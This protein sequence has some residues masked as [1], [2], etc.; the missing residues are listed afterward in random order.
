[1]GFLADPVKSTSDTVSHIGSVIAND[2]LANA[3]VSAVGAYF[4]V[5]TWMTAAGM[6]ANSLAQGKD[7]GQSLLSAGLSYGAG[8]GTNSLLA[9]PELAPSAPG[10][11]Q[12]GGGFTPIGAGVDNGS[13]GSK[14]LDIAKSFAGSSTGSQVLGSLGSALL[15]GGLNGPQ[16]MPNPTAP[17]APPAQ[18]MALSPTYFSGANGTAMSGPGASNSSTFLTGAGGVDPN[19]LTGKLGRTTLLGG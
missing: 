12:P 6:G 5:P 19:S 2:P 17:T 3:A 14:I 10:L 18:Q 9:G 4:G 16:N 8:Q 1:M 7:A 15:L 13:A 11:T